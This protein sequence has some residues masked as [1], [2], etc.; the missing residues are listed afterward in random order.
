LAS[1]DICIIACIIASFIIF[2]VNIARPSSEAETTCKPRKAET[3]QIQSMETKQHTAALIKQLEYKKHSI[4]VRAR[5]IAAE[6]DK[7]YETIEGVYYY[8]PALKR[9]QMIA[10][11]DTLYVQASKIQIEIDRLKA[12]KKR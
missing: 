11:S 2:I 7:E 8:Y 9:A 4:Q 5:L 12:G 1:I 3:I 10:Q 6:A